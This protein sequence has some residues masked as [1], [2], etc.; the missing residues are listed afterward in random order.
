MDLK[1]NLQTLEESLQYKSPFN[2]ASLIKIPW[3]VN[4][5]P[6]KYIEAKLFLNHYF[7]GRN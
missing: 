6:E 4:N 1:E 7:P 5:L 2:Y 3:E